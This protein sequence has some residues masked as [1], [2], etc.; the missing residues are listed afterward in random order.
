VGDDGF[1]TVSSGADEQSG[2]EEPLE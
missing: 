1:E 2:A